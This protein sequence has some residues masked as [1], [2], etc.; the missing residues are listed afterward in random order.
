MNTNERYGPSKSAYELLTEPSEGQL[1]MTGSASCFTLLYADNPL[2]FFIST[3]TDSLRLGCLIG[4]KQNKRKNSAMLDSPRLS[5]TL[6][7]DPSDTV[8]QIRSR[9]FRLTP[10]PPPQ[11]FPFVS[12]ITSPLSL[13]HHRATS[14]HILRTLFWTPLIHILELWRLNGLQKHSCYHLSTKYSRQYKN[15]SIMT[16]YG[17]YVILW[18]LQ[19][20]AKQMTGITRGGITV[21]LKLREMESNLMTSYSVVCIITVLAL[22]TDCVIITM[23]I[24]KW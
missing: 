18:M 6:C 4:I 7:C 3:G 22:V 8:S 14:V 11:T 21:R 19:K 13:I 24:I 10:Y 15:I 20:L 2:K 17:C 12:P 9:L 5:K 16:N 23:I 1:L